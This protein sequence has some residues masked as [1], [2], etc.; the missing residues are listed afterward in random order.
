MIMTDK[1]RLHS[2]VI[3]KLRP[4]GEESSYQ[5]KPEEAIGDEAQEFEAVAKDILHAFESKSANELAAGLKA[6]FAL[7]E[8]KEQE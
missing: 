4:D 6:F 1:K 2:M 3:A 8:S 5:A 7:C